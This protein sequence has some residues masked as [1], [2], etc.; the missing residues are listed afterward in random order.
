MRGTGQQVPFAIWELLF[1]PGA[2][3]FAVDRVRLIQEGMMVGTLTLTTPH[4]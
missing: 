4:Y 1:V 2:K 3:S